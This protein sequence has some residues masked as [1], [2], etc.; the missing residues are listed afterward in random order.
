[1]PEAAIGELD[2]NLRVEKA[3]QVEDLALFD[4]RKP[5][6]QLYGLYNP[7]TEPIFKRMPTEIAEQVSEGVVHLHKQTA[8]GLGDCIG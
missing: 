4:V 3:L 7:T 2:R 6:F 8:G 1:M 5:P